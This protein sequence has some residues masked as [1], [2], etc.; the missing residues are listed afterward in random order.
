M[1]IGTKLFSRPKKDKNLRAK[2]KKEV[3]ELKE[4]YGRELR[5]IRAIMVEKMTSLLEGKT[6]QGIKHKFGEE[7]MTKGVKFGK[8]NVAENLF[9][10]KNPYQRR[11]QL[12]RAR[13][14]QPVQ[15]PRTG[16][17]GQPTPASTVWWASW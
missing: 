8:K 4:A 3:E 15:G 17:A 7:I 6:S 12:R 5:G 10:D 13:G 1:V 2:S 14:G 11:E 16:T 9:P